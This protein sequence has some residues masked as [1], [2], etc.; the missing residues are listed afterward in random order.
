MAY[1]IKWTEKA[2]TGFDEVILF[3]EENWSS[4]EINNLAE[5]ID[6][7]ISFLAKHP[8]RYPKSSQHLFARKC[9]VDKN[10][11]LAYEVIEKLKEIRILDFGSNHKRPKY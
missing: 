8:L 5:R 9:I 1:K 10:N 4:K 2:E 6:E 7:V 3:L 11:Y